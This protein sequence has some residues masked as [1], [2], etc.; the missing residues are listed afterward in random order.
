MYIHV[1]ID[2]YIMAVKV[3]WNK[4]DVRKNKVVYKSFEKSFVDKY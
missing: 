3:K 4:I 2:Y 1:T